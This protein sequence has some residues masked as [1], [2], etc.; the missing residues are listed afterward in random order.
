[1]VFYKERYQ[2]EF[3]AVLSA[4]ISYDDDGSGTYETSEIDYIKDNRLY[5]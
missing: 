2:E 4:G 5:R 3:H 1:M